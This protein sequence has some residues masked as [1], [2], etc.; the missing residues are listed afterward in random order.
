[1]RYLVDILPK[2]NFW[3]AAY[4]VL[5]ALETS[6]GANELSVSNKEMIEVT[7]YLMPNLMNQDKE[8]ESTS[9]KTAR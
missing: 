2:C 3:K 9:P 6:T 4:I 8:L 5:I 7:K 1:M